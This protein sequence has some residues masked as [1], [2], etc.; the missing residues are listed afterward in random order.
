MT[1]AVRKEEERTKI[2]TRASQVSIASG[3]MSAINIIWKRGLS[4]RPLGVP[5]LL[6]P[7][8]LLKLPLVEVPKLA[9]QQRPCHPVLDNRLVMGI[10]VP[11]LGE[12]EPFSVIVLVDAAS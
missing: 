4:C 2:P 9:I 3:D 8:P 6:N 12:V 7:I 11:L 5:A 1:P 10:V